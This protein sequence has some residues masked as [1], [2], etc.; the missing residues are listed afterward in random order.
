MRRPFALEAAKTIFPFPRNAGAPA[1][2]WGV[3]ISRR[4]PVSTAT[5]ARRLQSD[6]LFST[7]TICL[8]LQEKDRPNM[9][10]PPVLPPAGASYTDLSRWFGARMPITFFWEPGFKTATLP[11]RPGHVLA[12]DA[13]DGAISDMPNRHNARAHPA[14]TRCLSWEARWLFISLRSVGIIGGHWPSQMRER[15]FCRGKDKRVS[16]Y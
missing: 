1:H 11:F 4:I 10:R 12:A 16:L 3:S 13:N 14:R 6:R 9:E 8:P 2:R 15:K 7:K 5:T